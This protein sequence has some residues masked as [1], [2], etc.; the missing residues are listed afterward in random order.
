M[1]LCFGNFWLRTI[2]LE[3]TMMCLDLDHIQ[4][5]SVSEKKRV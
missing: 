4:E 1:C 3:D 5:P 2:S